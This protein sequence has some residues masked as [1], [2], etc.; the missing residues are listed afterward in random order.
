MKSIA[1]LTSGGD[2]P[3]MNAVVRS[4]VRC[5]LGAGLHVYGIRKG[6]Q[7]LLEGRFEELDSRAVS[8]LL[9]LGGSV[10]ECA[11]CLEMQEP[12][13]P[14]QA[15]RILARR[16]IDG[17]IAIGGDGTF[18]GALEL[19]K[20][21]ISVIGVTGTIDNDIPGTDHTIGFDTA[22]DTLLW[23]L[24]KLRDTAQS[25][26]RTFV[27]EA[28]GRHSGWL[29]L[30]AGIA[31]G[32]DVILIPELPWSNEEVLATLQRR[33]DNGRT[34]NLVVIAEGA[35]RATDLA[36]WLNAQTPEELEVR[37]CIP[38][39]IQRGGA[40]TTFD[41]LLGTR[42]GAAA[43]EALLAGHGGVMVGDRAGG[44]VEVPLSEATSG[45]RTIDE[46]LYK[47]ALRVA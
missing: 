44:I 31:G 47:L 34:F 36:G 24:N 26:N 43:V 10:L 28:M 29:A 9:G 5:A 4:A 16:E 46:E 25:H 8:G 27:V 32:A 13:G 21:G 38:G 39:H 7:G 20:Q 33:T 12:Q 18:R 22:C 30:S 2:S 37:T 14:E 15:A 1:V 19:S 35:G 11:R 40:P 42:C 41:R 3:G 45:K 23:C 17:L 6:Y